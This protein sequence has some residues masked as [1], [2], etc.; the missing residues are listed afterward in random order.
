VHR[1]VEDPALR[2]AQMESNQRYY[3]RFMRPDALARYVL[4]TAAAK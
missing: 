4:D 2:A 1:L 3:Q